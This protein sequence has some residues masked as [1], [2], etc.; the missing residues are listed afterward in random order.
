MAFASGPV[1]KEWELSETSAEHIRVIL[2]PTSTYHAYSRGCNLSKLWRLLN[3]SQ[4]IFIFSVE[5]RIPSPADRTYRQSGI[6][7]RHKITLH[8]PGKAADVTQATLNSYFIDLDVFDQVK[9]FH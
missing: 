8:L 4:D 5:F 9:D 2:F 3:K 6:R 7:L 1:E